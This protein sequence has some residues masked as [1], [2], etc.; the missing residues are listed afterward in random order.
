[1]LGKPRPPEGDRREYGETR[2]PWEKPNCL[3][4]NL[5]L[6]NLAAHR[7]APV[8]DATSC[9]GYTRGPAYLQETGEMST[10]QAQEMRGLPTG[11]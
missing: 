4:S 10:G 11:R 3:K 5:D 6:V 9:A 8:T 7:K 2:V 1:M